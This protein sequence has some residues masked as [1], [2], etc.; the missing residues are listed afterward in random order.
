MSGLGAGSSLTTAA[1]PSSV[2]PG[3]AQVVAS[4]VGISR[5]R[6]D[7]ATYLATDAEYRIR[8]VIQ[9]ASKFMRHSKRR[10][11]KT[12][13]IAAA[14]RLR[15]LE[16]LYGFS[17]NESVPF[18]SY[19]VPG[20]SSTAGNNTLFFVGDEEL[21][22]RDILDGELPRAPLETTLALHWLAIEGIQPKIPQ[23][24]SSASFATSQTAQLVVGESAHGNTQGNI[25][26]EQNTGASSVTFRPRV[27]HVLSRE[28]QL[29]YELAIE[30]LTGETGE[31]DE[32]LRTACLA[33]I[34]KDP[35]L[36]QLVPYFVAFLFHH[37]TNH[38]RDLP[39]LQ[40]AMRLARALLENRHIGLEPY[41]HQ[42][43]PSVL[44][45]IVGRCLCRTADEDHWA[46]REYAAALL[47]DIHKTYG[48]AYENLLPRIAET[49]RVALVDEHKPL[50]TQ[51]GALVAFRAL[52]SALVQAHVAPVAAQLIECWEKQIEDELGDAPH[53][54]PDGRWAFEPR[55]SDMRR[56][57]AALAGALNM[58]A[59]ALAAQF[60]SKHAQTML[61]SC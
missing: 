47:A 9:E 41:L 32:T 43:M 46:L 27:R 38:T 12:A 33:S 23:N 20:E 45:C 44:T 6:E 35:G 19:S 60:G 22:L 15:N 29:Y 16:P 56:V 52:G 21:D 61:Q 55:W 39:Q 57:Y 28:L 8:E 18:V 13:D 49:L 59:D 40:I 37:I 48:G 42:L 53:D 34:A 50:T 58:N 2:R 7:V 3:T 31:T 30:A 25:A 10:R 24:P 54:S 5:L 14:M 17:S 36:Q 4:M 1:A 51:Y 26:G 11:L